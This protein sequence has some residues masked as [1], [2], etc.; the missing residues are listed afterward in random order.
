MKHKRA[1]FTLIEIAI[2]LAVTATLFMGIVTAT[3]GS[4]WNQRYFDSVQNYAEFL[5]S[6]YS[7]VSNPQSVGKGNS[8]T[9]AIYGK[10]VVFGENFDLQGQEI[11]DPAKFNYGQQIFVYDVVGDVAGTGTG[12][13]ATMLEKLHANVVVKGS[14]GWVPAGEAT[15]FVPK[16]GAEIET[17]EPGVSFTGSILVVRHPRSGTINTLYSPT[18]IQ[19]NQAIGQANGPG[20]NAATVENL[21]SNVLTATGESAFRVEELSFCVNPYGYRAVT[22]NR[23]EI[24]LAENA[25]NASAVQIID[26]DSAENRCKT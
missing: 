1:G 12:N 14:D 16:W 15:D 8:E 26:L 2:F 21:L 20:G 6:I 3:Q 22:D 23:W 5:R 19:V 25:R 18:I 11:E 24:R 7:Q 13:A 10:L 4:I 9:T 17:L